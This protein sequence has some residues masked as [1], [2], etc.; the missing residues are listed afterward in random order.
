VTRVM[1]LFLASASAS[2]DARDPAKNTRVLL[3][4][5]HRD[6]QREIAISEREERATQ[7]EI[8][9]LAKKG[10]LDAVKRRAGD[11]IRQRAQTTRMRKLVSQIKTL[12]T[13][14]RTM[15]TVQQMSLAMRQITQSMVSMNRVLNLAS[16]TK[17]IETFQKQ[18]MAMDEKGEALEHVLTQ[19]DPEQEK[20]SAELVSQVLDEMGIDLQAQLSAATVKKD[21]VKLEDA[22]NRDLEA[23]LAKLMGQN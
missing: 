23:R 18:S 5:A 13:T 19:L 12:Q 6:I 22:A 16:L 10:D 20:A 3:R 15:Q 2:R 17:T 21:M 14:I 4:G 8:R 1:D 7:A 11:L 9:Q